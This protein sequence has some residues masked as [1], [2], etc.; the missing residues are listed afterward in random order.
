MSEYRGVRHKVC[1]SGTQ[2]YEDKTRVPVSS[3]I[4]KRRDF[5]RDLR[6][7]LELESSLCG[8][9]YWQEEVLVLV[10]TP[11]PC[12]RTLELAILAPF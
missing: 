8:D 3:N 11:K 1:S 5:L 6:T 7:I 10:G 9:N 4:E 2:H 12:Y